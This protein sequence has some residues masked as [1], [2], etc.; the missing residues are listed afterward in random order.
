[1][2]KI[3]RRIA[4]AAFVSL[5][6]SSAHAQDAAANYPNKPVRMI[7]GLA[8]GGTVDLLA[9]MVAEKLTASLGQPFVVETRLGANGVV[10]TRAAL[11]APADGHTI[12]VGGSSAMV[13]NP[14]TFTS[15]PYPAGDLLTLTI[16][17]DYPSVIATKNDLPVKDWKELVALAKEKNGSLI[18]G[19]ASIPFRLYMEDIMAKV[20][21]KMRYVPYQGGM[22]AVQAALTGTVDV[23]VS[24]T[25]TTVAMINEGKIRAIAV[26]GKQRSSVLPNVP[27][28]EEA[29]LPGI[30]VTAFTAL[31]VH[32]NTPP[33]IV[34]K[35]HREIAK[36][37]DSPD[38]KARMVEWGINPLGSLTVAQA[39]ARVEAEKATYKP[40]ADA[41]G[42]KVDP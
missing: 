41:L 39:N 22:Q 5:L 33:A 27:T 1:M 40:L 16:L 25:G 23:V 12:V 37:L 4:A 34:E 8:A 3:T 21:I 17:G 20:G 42:I 29:G 13:F 31:G 2:L 36:A 15:L 19:P 38:I 32:K 24:D 11:D 9:R 26:T 18:F 35:L 30:N 28:L 14:I 6:A 7:S 10:A